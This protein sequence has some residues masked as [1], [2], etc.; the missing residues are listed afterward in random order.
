[1]GDRGLRSLRL[2]ENMFLALLE[3]LTAGLHLWSD[4]N[5]TKYLDAIYELKHKWYEEYKKAPADRS[6]AVL[7]NLDVELRI[8]AA[9]FVASVGKPEV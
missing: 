9:A 4:K 6:N 7:D 3:T 8:C 2:K 1:M 5:K